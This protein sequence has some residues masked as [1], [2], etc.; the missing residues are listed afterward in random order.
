MIVKFVKWIAI[1]ALFL[2]LFWQPFAQNR[3]LL[4]YVVW[5]GAI[6]VLRRRFV[7]VGT[8]GLV[9]S[10]QWLGFS[11]PSGRS[12]FLPPYLWF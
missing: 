2:A 11:T 1:A 4:E 12:P 9:Y 5:V 6:V 10:S 8:S 7:P 3:I